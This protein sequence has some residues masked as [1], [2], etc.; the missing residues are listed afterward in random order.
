VDVLGMIVSIHPL[1]PLQGAIRS[2]GLVPAAE[3]MRHADRRVR[4]GGIMVSYKTVSTK[5]GEPMSMITLEDLSGMFDAVVFPEAYRRHASVLRT[6]SDRGLCLEGKIQVDFGA[7]NLI[8]DKVEPLNKALRLT[9]ERWGNDWSIAG[10]GSRSMSTGEE[11]VME[12]EDT[13]L[14]VHIVA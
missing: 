14:N 10:T 4:M 13:K 6:Q 2:A 12:E 9:G 11:R 7:P 5:K 3:I 8:V 1:E